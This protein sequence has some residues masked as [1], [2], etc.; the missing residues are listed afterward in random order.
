MFPQSMTRIN[1][2]PKM[3][4]EKMRK[5]DG[6]KSEMNFVEKKIISHF[7]FSL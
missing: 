4:G 3:D 1:V 5:V 7:F 6:G 2:F